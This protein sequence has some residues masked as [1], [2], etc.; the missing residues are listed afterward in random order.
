MKQSIQIVVIILLLFSVNSVNAQSMFSVYKSEDGHEVYSTINGD[1]LTVIDNGIPGL[2]IF[3]GYDATYAFYS[4][5]SSGTVFMTRDTKRIV[6]NSISYN[7]V[8]VKT[9][10]NESNINNVPIQNYAPT[11][12]NTNSNT[13]TLKRKICTYCNGTG[14]IDSEISA[15]GSLDQKWCPQCNKWVSPTH[16]HGCKTCP[17]CLGKGYT[18][19]Y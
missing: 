15:Y 8:S 4:N 14:H 5:Q 7:F 9:F 19:S 12:N 17:V 3:S 11:Q 2:F 10:N 16:C 6:I 1:I 18:E 13:L